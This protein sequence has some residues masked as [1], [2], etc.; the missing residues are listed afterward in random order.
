MSDTA[1]APA[2]RKRS[3][4]KP[5]TSLGR[6]MN[7]V[8]RAA[9]RRARFR[10]MSQALA[11]IQADLDALQRASNL[12]EAKALGAVAKGR[13]AAAIAGVDLDQRGDV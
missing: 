5:I 9:R 13:A 3:G 12:G 11:E 6:A 7:E 2:T 4:R 10:L 8:E 1:A